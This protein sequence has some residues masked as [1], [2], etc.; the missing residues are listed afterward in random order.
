MFVFASLTETFGNVTLEAMASGLAVVAYNHAAAGELIENG[1]NGMLASHESSVHFEMAAQG[2]LNTPQLLTHIRT[3]ARST[4]QTM[5]W[6]MVVEKTESVIFDVI[7]NKQLSIPVRSRV[8]PT[9]DL[10][11]QEQV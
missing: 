7:N 6:D 5:G 11:S 8:S 4:A 2:L 3:Q 1:V 9:L 10:V